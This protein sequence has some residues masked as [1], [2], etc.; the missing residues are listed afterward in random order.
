MLPLEAKQAKLIADEYN[1]PNPEKALKILLGAVE[2][3][4][5]KGAYESWVCCRSID[6]EA[7]KEQILALGYTYRTQPVHEDG[8]VMVNLHWA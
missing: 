7:A 3:A 4:A 8:D 5:K 1:A 6:L 2:K